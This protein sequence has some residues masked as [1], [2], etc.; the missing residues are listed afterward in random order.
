MHNHLTDR[1][2]QR[3][4]KGW[5]EMWLTNQLV[6]NKSLPQEIVEEI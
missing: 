1:H 2:K 3:N 5:H 4:A 6:G